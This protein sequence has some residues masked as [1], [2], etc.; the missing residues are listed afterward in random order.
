MLSISLI[1]PQAKVVV[2][3]CSF[4]GAGNTA[5]IGKQ[6][7][8]LGKGKSMMTNTASDNFQNWIETVSDRGLKGLWLKYCANDETVQTINP[9]DCHKAFLIYEEMS[10]RNLNSMDFMDF[11]GL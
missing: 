3:D 2:A 10:D 1:L 8:S 6:S 7:A 9:I 5:L 4:M 11:D